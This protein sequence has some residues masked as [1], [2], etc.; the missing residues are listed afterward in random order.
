[1]LELTCKWLA[2]A[3]AGTW[4]ERH[5]RDG[6]HLFLRRFEEIQP[7]FGQSV[8]PTVINLALAHSF[9]ANDRAVCSEYQLL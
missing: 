1:M 7:E 2:W 4:R 9:L 6:R 8:L 5:R 3:V